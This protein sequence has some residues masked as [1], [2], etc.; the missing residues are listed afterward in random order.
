MGDIGA[1]RSTLELAL[2]TARRSRNVGHEAITLY[3]LATA[4][5]MEGAYDRG[6]ELG[7]R[8]MRILPLPVARRSG[9]W[10]TQRK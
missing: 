3:S 7:L 10:G 5:M 8:A 1:A 9:T 6:K 4:H 2:E